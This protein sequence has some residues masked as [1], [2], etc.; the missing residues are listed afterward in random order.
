MAQAGTTNRPLS[1][2]LQIWR[3]GP[4]MFVSIMH[5]VTGSGNVVGIAILLWWLGAMA[6]GKAAYDT[7]AWLA[8]TPIGYIVL[9]G[10]TWSFFTH[11]MSG[12]R[13]FVLDI[14]AGYELDTNKVWSIVCPVMGVLLTVLFWAILLLR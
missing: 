6:S 8:T 4:A 11:M 10:I 9:V 5:R 3:W 7:F 12:L 14:G 1:P 2:H 13:H